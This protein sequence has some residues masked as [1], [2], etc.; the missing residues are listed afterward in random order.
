MKKIVSMALA[1]GLGISLLAGCGSKSQSQ[2][3]ENGSAQADTSTAVEAVSDSIAEGDIPD[4]VYVIWVQDVETQEPIKDAKVQLCSDQMCQMAV[5]DPNGVASFKTDPGDY[6][7]H[8]LAA[9]EGYDGTDEELTLTADKR[10][11]VLNLKRNGDYTDSEE[12]PESSQ[13]PA[14]HQKTDSSWSFE[15]TGFDM[16][17]PEYFKDYMGQIYMQDPGE[18]QMGGGVFFGYLG[19]IGRT[20]EEREALTELLLN[21]DKNDPEDEATG[22]EATETYTS[23]GQ[24]PFLVITAIKDG[25]DFDD[26]MNIIFNDVDDVTRVGEIGEAD[27]YTYYYIVPDTEKYVAPYKDIL[28]EEM[29]AEYRSLAESAEDIAA[30][31]HVKGPHPTIQPTEMGSVLSFETTDLDGNPV[32]SEDLFSEHSVTMINVWTT[33]CNLCQDE[34]SD[35]EK[36][37]RDIEEHGCHVIGICNDTLGGDESTVELAKSILQENGVTY[38][39]LV[40]TQEIVDQLVINGYPTT[41]FVGSDGEILTNPVS[42]PNFDLYHERLE[43]ALASLG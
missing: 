31:V 24:I 18:P 11:D 13:D 35:L 17:V 41:Y 6:T 3:T 16:D 38:T 9:P 27:S 2:T 19:F 28:S 10:M 26:A 12:T 40:S 1:L 14:T 43:Q 39:N 15:Q 21:L 29:L 22:D 34:M 20:D 30:G 8:L 23:V 32:K 7:A 25:V 5:S 33:W 4:G 42:G 37:N 36:L